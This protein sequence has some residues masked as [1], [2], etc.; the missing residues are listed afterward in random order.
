MACVWYLCDNIFRPHFEAFYQQNDSR[1]PYNQ[2]LKWD[3][4]MLWC[5]EPKRNFKLFFSNRCFLFINFTIK[6]RIPPMGKWQL[7]D[8]VQ[9][10]T[11]IWFSGYY[12]SIFSRVQRLYIL[13]CRSVC[14]SVGR[15]V[16]H[17]FECNIDHKWGHLS[18]SK[19]H[20][21]H[22]LSHLS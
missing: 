17:L 2:F 16:M 6:C 21:S 13:L 22:I 4:T 8:T 15:S 3:I 20:S 11:D 19:D 18:H 7:H 9:A 12:P 5:F 14:L 1:L 10:K